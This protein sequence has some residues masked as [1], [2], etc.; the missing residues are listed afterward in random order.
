M[1]IGCLKYCLIRESY[2]FWS[3]EYRFGLN[4]YHNYQ[5]NSLSPK[6]YRHLC[7]IFLLQAGTK[8]FR[9][10]HQQ[11]KKSKSYILTRDKEVALLS[12]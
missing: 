12:S 4:I 10:S 2:Q 7:E 11:E 1:Q 8:E 3:S 9:G 6:Q 5:L